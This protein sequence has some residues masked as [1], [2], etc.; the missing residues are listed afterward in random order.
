M[1]VNPVIM[2]GKI[3]LCDRILFPLLFIVWVTDRLKVFTNCGLEEQVTLNA[4]RGVHSLPLFCQTGRWGLSY[5][6]RNSPFSFLSHNNFNMI[7]SML[8]NNIL[9]YI[10]NLYHTDVLQCTLFIT[11]Q[12]LVWMTTANQCTRIKIN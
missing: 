11:S 4:Q 10:Q 7:T 9:L 6:H 3:K 2:T 8:Q 1:N 12:C 5:Q